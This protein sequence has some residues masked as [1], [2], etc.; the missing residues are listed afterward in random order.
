[1]YLIDRFSQ[2]LRCEVV[3]HFINTWD[4]KYPLSRNFY[5]RTCLKFAFAK[6]IAAM[7]ERPHVQLCKCKSRNSLNLT[8]N[9]DTLYLTSSLFMWLKFAQPKTR[10]WRSTLTLRMCHGCVLLV[11]LNLTIRTL[12]LQHFMSIEKKSHIELFQNGLVQEF[13]RLK[14]LIILEQLITWVVEKKHNKIKNNNLSEQ[15]FKVYWKIRIDDRGIRDQGSVKIT[16]K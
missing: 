15:N 14:V 2:L 6:K 4:I 9:L 3:L 16:W 1:M 5:L 10:Q 7:Y 8:F 13:Y 11:A 12:Y